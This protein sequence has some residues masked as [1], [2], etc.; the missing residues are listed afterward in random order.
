MTSRIKTSSKKLF[1]TPM[2]RKFKETPSSRQHIGGV[3]ESAP[4]IPPEDDRQ[5]ELM[6]ADIITR[7]ERIEEKFDENVYPPQSAMKPE[8]IKRIKKAQA[9]IRKGKGK[10]YNS[11]DDFFREIEA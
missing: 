1:L 7:L 2:K 8:F 3:Y 11:I 4:N 9:D 10:T 6:L 5:I